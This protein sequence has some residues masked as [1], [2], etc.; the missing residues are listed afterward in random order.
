M[1]EE[2]GLILALQGR[3]SVKVSQHRTAWIYSSGEKDP[4]DGTDKCFVRWMLLKTR[5][6]TDIIFH[7]R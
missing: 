2:L 7:M 4:Q 3:I 1:K 5:Y 6:S